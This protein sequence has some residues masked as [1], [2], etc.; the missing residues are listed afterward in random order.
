[1]R[2][3]NSIEELIGNTPILRANK[4]KEKLNLK[5]NLLL[6]LECFNPMCS[7]KD[8]T[9]YSMLQDAISNLQVNKNTVIIAPTSRNTGIALAYL[10]VVKHIKLI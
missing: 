4:L 1:M 3:V 5:G 2:V 10:C 7:I 8:R 9:S 6:K